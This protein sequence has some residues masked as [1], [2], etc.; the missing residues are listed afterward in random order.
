MDPAVRRDLLSLDKDNANT[1]ARHLVM[2]G[3]LVDEDPELALL[4]ARAAR[5]RAGRI[6]V[7]REAA[8]ITAYHAGEWLKLSPSFVLPVEWLADRV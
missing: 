8:G 6:A 7:V 2:A 1:V 4:H 5:Q 3:K